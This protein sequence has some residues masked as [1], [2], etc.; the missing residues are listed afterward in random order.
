MI[1]IWF[2]PES[3]RFYIARDQP[4]KALQILAY[5]HADGDEQDKV[6]QLEYLEIR[7]AF[8]LDKEEEKNSNFM[9]FFKTPGNRKRFF[10]ITALSV[11]YQWSGNGLISYYLSLI[12]NSIGI[13]KA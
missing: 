8:A 10:L 3:P 2:I 1:F 7:T 9:D 12:M 13:T 6:V 11:F 4:E 5:Y